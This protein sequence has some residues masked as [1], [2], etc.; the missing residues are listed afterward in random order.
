MTDGS[1]PPVHP[2]AHRVAVL[3]LTYGDRIDLFE[4][5]AAAVAREGVGSLLVL[6]N[7]LADGPARRLA[8]CAATAPDRLGL[9]IEIVTRP[10]NRGS[11]EGFTA[12][13][14]TAAART[15]L[16]AVWFMDDDNCPQPGCLDRLLRE[17]AARD[18]AAVSAVR[19]DR[20]Y[21]LDA[22]AG[23]PVNL[24]RPGEVF[25][26][27]L[28]RTAARI[29]GR[30]IP[31]RRNH[32]GAAAGAAENAPPASVPFPRVPYGGLLVPAALVRRT[33]PPRADFVLY[34]D[35]Y[36]YSARLAAA[37]GLWLVGDARVDDLE[38]SW[39]A[40]G[41]GRTAAEAA[42][43]RVSQ[44]QRLATMPPDFRLFYSVRNAVFLDRA[45]ARGAAGAGGWFWINLG[46]F[47][48]P[49]LLRA[50]LQGRGGNLR[51]L[52]LALQGALDGRLGAD[53]RF[54]LP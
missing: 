48:L 21:L 20:R 52:R 22:A 45:R 3:T 23:R 51:T 15:D 38:A 8:A 27:D 47:A 40:S 33:D 31:P 46:A 28:R 6:S 50:A 41:A 9:V 32:R 37:G 17:S 42:A 10:E 26:V 11:A 2:D 36:E 49:V 19:T 35:D 4:R 30:V 7:G 12:L 39:N 14:A 25:G 43:R 53:P 29:L 18:G 16:A 1:P 13:L 34:A 54:P 5:M 44:A 24:P